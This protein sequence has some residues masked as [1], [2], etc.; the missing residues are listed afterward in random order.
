MRTKTIR[1]IEYIVIIALG[2]LMLYPIFW[3]VSSS[4]KE[5]SEILSSSFKLIPETFHFENYINGWRGFECRFLV[6][7]RNK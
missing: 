5:N 2:L 4:L 1:L 7:R 3:L 6:E